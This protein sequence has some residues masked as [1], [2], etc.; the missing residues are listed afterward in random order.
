MRIIRL[1]I[2]DIYPKPEPGDLVELNNEE[3]RHGVLS[4]RLKPGD[5]VELLGVYG[6]A[7]AIVVEAKK[8]PSPS[9]TLTLKSPFLKKDTP[10]GPTLI[11]PLIRTTRFEWALEKSVELGASKII[12]YIS[13]RTRIQETEIGAEKTARWER[14]AAEAKKQSGSLEPFHIHKPVKLLEFLANFRVE[15]AQLFFLDID[16]APLEN[17]EGKTNIVILVGPEGG[18]SLEERKAALT[19][20]F[21]PHSL[22]SHNLKTETA[23]LAALSRLLLM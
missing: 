8:T 13:S 12:P 7:E 9:L 15:N 17:Q 21:S 10:P 14:I 20:N 16:G 1:F 23:A 6:K 4:L 3:A 18:F 19:A 5:F 2:K 11:L 22:G